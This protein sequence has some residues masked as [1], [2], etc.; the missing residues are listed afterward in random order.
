MRANESRPGA[1]RAAVNEELQSAPVGNDS[2]FTPDHQQITSQ[3][4]AED[5]EQDHDFGPDEDLPARD[6]PEPDFRRETL[7]DLAGHHQE[8][9]WIAME[10]AADNVDRLIHVAGAGWFYWDGRRWAADVKDKRATCAVLEVVRRLAPDSLGHKARWRALESAQKASGIKSVLTLAAAQPGISVDISEL[11]ADPF[12]LNCANGILDLRTGELR[13]HDPTEHHTKVTRAAYDA[14]AVSKAW[15][16][17]LDTSLPDVEV[18][19]FLMR[20]LGLGLV[21]EVLEHV[22]VFATG[23]GRNGKGVLYECVMHA[24]G[25]YATTGAEG[26]LERAKS[27]A[28]GPSP[29]LADLRGV[30][31]AVLSETEEGAR[32]A[33]ALMKRLTGGDPIKARFLHE[34]FF[35]FIPSHTLLYVSNFLPKL[36]SDDPAVWERA[37]VVPFD[38]VIPKEDRD[39]EL[40]KKIQAN[41]EAVLASLVAG[42]QEY[43]QRG[44]DEPQAVQVATQSYAQSQDD[45]LRFVQE[46]CESCPGGGDTTTELF[47][48]YETWASVEGVHP[49]QML[50]RKKFGEALDRLG[51][52]AVKGARGMVRKG[53]AWCD[54]RARLTPQQV[55]QTVTNVTQLRPDTY[56][57]I[58][59]N[60]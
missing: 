19:D 7:R 50:G 13:P 22:L 10:F 55:Q 11:D 1:N 3:V 16:G 33:P 21:G 45:V 38:V 31:L 24:M 37:R 20:Y 18:R 2:H 5:V 26:L 23:A 35:E 60:G 42:L 46:E 32:F 59:F 53:L 14:N 9:A 17:Y 58:E 8:H 41:P 54:P 52:T 28:N 44:L 57:P 34:N 40:K 12:A 43:W 56:A 27:N 47:G 49:D 39:P 48:R 30:R 4:A 15:Q 36:P 25:D 6:E 51:Y 29:S